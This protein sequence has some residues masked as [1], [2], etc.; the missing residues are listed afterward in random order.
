MGPTRLRERL[1]VDLLG[2][3]APGLLLE[4][5]TLTSRADLERVTQRAGLR[6]LSASIVEGIA[7]WQ[8]NR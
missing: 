4:C 2:V 3:N 1:P 7:A 6:E 8:A 5:A